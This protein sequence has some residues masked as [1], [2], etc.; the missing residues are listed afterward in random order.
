MEL[1]K[2]LSTWDWGKASAAMNS[3]FEKIKLEL[4]K[5]RF[6]SILTFC[7]G[8]FSTEV[9]FLA[10]FPT[11]K[12][13]EYAF[14]GSPWP[15][16]VYEWTDTK[17]VNTGIA[18]QLGEGIFMELLKQHIDNTTVLW[19]DKEKYIY[20]LGGG[21]PPAGDTFTLTAGI[22]TANV[23]QCE[24]TATGATVGDVVKIEVTA[25]KSSY[26]VTAKKGGTVTVKI[27]P[28]TGY[29]VQKLNVDTVSQGAVDN[30][31]FEDVQ[32]EHTMY[33]WMEVAVDEQPVDFLVR[34]DKPEVYYS[35]THVAL[36][37]IKGDYPDGLTQDVTLRCVKTAKERRMAND[38]NKQR[39]ELI[40]LAVLKH[41]NQ[42]SMHTLTIDGAGLLTYDCASLGGFR[43]QSVD[44]IVF[45]NVG[46]INFANYIDGGTPDEIAAIMFIGSGTDYVRN[47]AIWDCIFN[48]ISTT[49][50]TT[51]STYTISTKYTENVYFQ[52]SEFKGNA[53]LT[54]KM[55]NSRLAAF[56]KNNISGNF[57]EGAVGHAGLFDVTNGYQ[58][59]LEDN[60]LDGTTFRESLMYLTSID[61]I[62][63]R[64]NRVSKGARVA[65]LAANTSIRNFVVEDNLIINPLNSPVFGWIHELFSSSTDI[66]RFVFNSNT[67][68][69]GGNDYL[70]FICRFT[71]ADVRS[72]EMYNNIIV[73]PDASLTSSKLNMFLFKTL[74]ALNMGYNLFKTSVKDPDKGQTHGVIV[75]VENPDD[76]AD[77]LTIK[78]GNSRL[79]SYLRTNGHDTETMLIPKG[80]KL[81]D[82]EA[83]GSTYAITPGYD[84]D[85]PAVND[86]VSE[87]DYQYKKKNAAKNSRGCYNLSGTVINE[88]GDAATGYAG[89][90]VSEKE[91]FDN[92]LMYST[93]SDSVL[94]LT[95]NT[96][97]RNRLVR[98]A[99][100]GTQH[101]T[102]ALGKYVLMH[103][104]AEINGNDE[105]LADELYTI[106]I[107]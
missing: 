12:T 21:A 24:V 22:N 54:F 18:P 106:K 99:V 26:T 50:K 48:G 3:N 15:G 76:N 11:G 103:A 7:K 85:Y 93:M 83:G 20:S 45:R 62:Y 25:D 105:Y 56:V 16:T 77:S 61:N 74:G 91:T 57:R 37:A 55:S 29:Q 88:A 2:I 49:N 72:S 41:W 40:F 96:L 28:K 30:Y 79:L 71:Q 104:A 47:L 92:A 34:S 8:Y 9:R 51:C 65:E 35:N 60:E 19:N 63:L 69:M 70:Q 53:G 43:L 52:G 38:E 17:W 100:E 33:I 101:K 75:S 73:D 31:T 89:E 68:W 80:Y 6:A 82:I 27:V 64:R 107:D 59:I 5:L 13:G 67:A 1:N 102:L 95:H 78:G 39:N 87:T 97:N 32:K 98:W 46:F 84:N 58:L 10:K 42:R 14:V 23:G 44:N 81:L 86:F 36:N 90:D 94:L 66:G 4:M